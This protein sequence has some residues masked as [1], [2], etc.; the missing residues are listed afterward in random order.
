LRWMDYRCDD[1]PTLKELREAVS[2]LLELLSS[3]S[4]E[5]DRSSD[6]P[7]S[8]CDNGMSRQSLLE[9]LER[10]DGS[11][12]LRLVL[13][14]I[15]PLPGEL[16]HH[17][18]TANYLRKREGNHGDWLA[19]LDAKPPCK[20]IVQ[21]M[22][23]DTYAYVHPAEPRTLSVREAARIQTFPDWFRLGSVGLVDGFRVI[24]NAVP[25]LLRAQLG[26]QLA[27]LLARYEAAAGGGAETPDLAV[28]GAGN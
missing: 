2:T 20:T 5:E 11:L 25:P 26:E 18:L 4:K 23:K 1:S 24:G 15:A 19:R 8:S 12:S 13:E 3:T 14:G 9:L 10:L 27:D 6:D 17:L 28:A 7:P 22:G 21:H 16:G